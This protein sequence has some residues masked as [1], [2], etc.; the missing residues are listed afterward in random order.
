[1]KKKYVTIRDIAERAGVS[2]NTV[3]R[4]LNNKPDISEETRKKILKIARELGYV[5]NATASS[6]RSKQ[7]NIVGVIIADSA[8][9][10]YAEVLKGIEAASRKYG[11]QIMLM[12]TERVYENEEKA[13]D[14]LLQRRVDGLL[15]T[16]VQD[17]AEDIKALMQ[18]NVPFVI[19]GRHFEEFEVDEI[20]SDEIKGGYLATKHLIERGKRNILMISGYLFK[21]A[22][23]M[24]LEGYKKALREHGM[25]FRED[26]VIV[27]DIDIEN[28]Y[29]AV[30]KALNEGLKFD[31]VFCYNDLMAFGVI[32]ALKE[33]GFQIP[34]DVAVIGYD[35]IVY[36]SLVCPPLSTIRIKK[37][38]MGFEAFRMLLQKIKGRRKRRKRVILDVELVVRE[39]T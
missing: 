13:I 7:T 32:K 11:Y 14:V 8:N 17:K 27:T 20:H 33:R 18:R 37:F 28:G 4:A 12:N 3:S 35:D 23:Y 16:P 6:L 21:S 19:V 25:P 39:T 30:Q 10:F 1:M 36:S 31:G 26:M 5:K 2:I 22:A 9:P 38:E 29:Q 24:R 15:I 34:E